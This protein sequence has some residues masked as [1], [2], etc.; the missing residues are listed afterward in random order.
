MSDRT[1]TSPFKVI[2]IFFISLVGSPE[3]KKKWWGW[4][5]KRVVIVPSIYDK[6][7]Y[8]PAVNVKNVSGNIWTLLLCRNQF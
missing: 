6:Q 8:L 2:E 4:D 5:T 3:K 1:S 7:T